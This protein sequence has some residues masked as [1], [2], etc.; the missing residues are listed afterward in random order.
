MYVRE[1]KRGTCLGPPFATVMCK[2][3][4]FA[5][6]WSPTAT[7]LY[8]WDNLLSKGPPTS[9]VMWKYLA[10]KGS[11]N[12][13]NATFLSKGPLTSLISSAS[14]SNLGDRSLLWGAKWWRDWNFGPPVTACPQIGGME[15]GWYGSALQHKA[16]FRCRTAVNFHNSNGT[17][18]CFLV[19]LFILSTF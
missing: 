2:V 15:C 11:Q 19:L 8:K 6:K 4:Y 9:G 16:E 1:G 12:T 17:K 18:N 14:Y 3:A 10:F 13:C 5:F 7:A